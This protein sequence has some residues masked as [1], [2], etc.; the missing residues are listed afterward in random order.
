MLY[1]YFTRHGE[2]IWNTQSRMQGRLDSPLTEKGLQQAR[3]LATQLQAVP[4]DLVWS[5]PAPRAM[6]T[7]EQILAP[8]SQPISVRVDER[9]NEMNLGDWEGLSVDEARAADPSNLQAFLYEPQ[10]FRPA[11]EGESFRQVMDRMADFLRDMENASQSCCQN[12]QDQ[13][14][15]IVSH[16]I[17]LKALL[18]LMQGRPLAMLRDGPPIRQAALYRA[19]MNGRWQIETPA[20]T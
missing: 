19:W 18:A 4:L 11:G 8:R 10:K 9:I 5:S 14:W 17:T 16:N 7:V 12:G 1:L 6:K 13:H 2:T 20:D 3:Q 15:L